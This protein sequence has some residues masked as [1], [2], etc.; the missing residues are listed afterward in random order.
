MTTQCPKQPCPTPRWIETQHLNSWRLQAGRLTTLPR[1]SMEAGSGLCG[2]LVRGVQCSFAEWK[3]HDSGVSLSGFVRPRPSSWQAL[4]ISCVY[5]V[6]TELA[7]TTGLDPSWQKGNSRTTRNIMNSAG[8]CM[9][10]LGIELNAMELGT[11]RSDVV[12]PLKGIWDGQAWNVVKTSHKNAVLFK[13]SAAVCQVPH[14]REC[15]LLHL[16]S[17]QNLQTPVRISQT[18][19]YII[20]NAAPYSSYDHHYYVQALFFEKY[21]DST[22]DP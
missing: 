1:T 18:N 13:S 3:C 16:P 6:L 20:P 19:L 11:R 5:P 4:F 8:L 22:E 21:P 7:P 14:F 12:R 9:R 2:F 17:S 15:R 10:S